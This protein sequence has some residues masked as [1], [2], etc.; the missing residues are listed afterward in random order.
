MENIDLEKAEIKKKL[1]RDYQK[2]LEITQKFN[3]VSIEDAV[4]SAGFTLHGYCSKCHHWHRHNSKIGQ[5][6]WEYCHI[7]GGRTE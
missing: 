4:V 7:R 5:K 2:M 3:G 6:H 1:Q